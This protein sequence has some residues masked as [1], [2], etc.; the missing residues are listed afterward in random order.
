[1]ASSF[2]KPLVSSS[3]SLEASTTIGAP[4]VGALTK[5]DNV[6]PF[7]IFWPELFCKG[8]ADVLR[9]TSGV[10]WVNSDLF[11]PSELSLSMMVSVSEDC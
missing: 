11:D 2:G 6:L 9:A 4:L 10:A 1:M 7:S 3:A 5:S 8:P